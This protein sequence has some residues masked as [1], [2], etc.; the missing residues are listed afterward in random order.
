MIKPIKI[1]KTKKGDKTNLFIYFGD[2][3]G[4][5][6]PTS[7][8]LSQVRWNNRFIKIGTTSIWADPR[9][10][11]TKR[12]GIFKHKLLHVIGFSHPQKTKLYKVVL[13]PFFF[14]TKDR[15]MILILS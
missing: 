6:V 3:M 12:Q 2:K 4:N 11:G 13:S 10:N 15:E 9:T 14:V 1:E 7:Q 5:T 8:D